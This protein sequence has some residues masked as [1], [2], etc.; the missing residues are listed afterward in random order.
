MVVRQGLVEVTRGSVEQAAGAGRG[1][2]DPRPRQGPCAL[3]H[4]PDQA[5]GAFGVAEPDDR[6]GV[7]GVEPVA[8]GLAVV[9]QFLD[10]LGAGELPVCLGEV[11]GRQGHGPQHRPG[12]ALEDDVRGRLDPAQYLRAR[13]PGTVKIT[14][15]AAPQAF[16]AQRHE[17]V[18]LLLGLLGEVERLLR[19]CPGPVHAPGHHL[20]P[21]Q[22]GEHATG[23]RLVALLAECAQQVFEPLPGGAEVVEVPCPERGHRTHLPGGEVAL[24]RHPL[25]DRRVVG[26]AP[27]QQLEQCEVVQG[28]AV[29]DGVLV[30]VEQRQRC[31]AVRHADVGVIGL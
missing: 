11:A 26:A 27:R 5:L 7:V 22:V 24:E 25:L 10:L 21:G 3:L 31:L 13:R 16:R 30:L 28:E 29:Q 1:G 9:H 8:G 17:Q 18:D 14:R 2:Q 4:A 12:H 20:D 23:G 6:F 15:L 19:Q